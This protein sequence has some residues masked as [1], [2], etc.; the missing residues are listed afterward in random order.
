M[1]QA[2]AVTDERGETPLDPCGSYPDGGPEIKRRRPGGGR[3]PGRVSG[4]RRDQRE[5]MLRRPAYLDRENW[6][7][8]VAFPGE[9]AEAD[10]AIRLS[11][12]ELFAPSAW[13]PAVRRKRFADG[14]IRPARPAQIVP[15]FGRFMFARFSLADPDWHRIKDLDGVQRL[16]GSAGA[17]GIP[18]PIAETAIAA[19]RAL[20]QME[21][22]DCFYP[23]GAFKRLAKQQE[24]SDPETEPFE[25]GELIRILT[26]VYAGFEAACEWSDRRRVGFRTSIFGRDVKATADRRDVAAA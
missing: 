3:K 21:L 17:P 24:L 14:S 12:F 20:P 1:N 9:Q 5:Q 4:S 13:L 6:Y 22:N 2:A 25:A 16:L 15:L 23:D 19:I 18:A 10:K 26:G 8:V 7:C 11:G